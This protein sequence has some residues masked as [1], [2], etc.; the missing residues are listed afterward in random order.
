ML[1]GQQRIVVSKHGVIGLMGLPPRWK[2]LKRG[3]ESTQ[4]WS[5]AVETP[6]AER[7]LAL[8][9]PAVLKALAKLPSHRLFLGRLAVTAEAVAG[10]ARIAHLS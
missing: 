3:F 2:T 7:V 8:R 10:C 9:R 6:S 4:V 5:A 1:L